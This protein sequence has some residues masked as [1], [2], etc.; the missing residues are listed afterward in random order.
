MDELA[1]SFLIHYSGGDD[2][3]ADVTF[4]QRYFLGFFCW[5]CSGLLSGSLGEGCLT[6][7][8][9]LLRLCTIFYPR[10]V[11]SAAIRVRS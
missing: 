7:G 3:L 11:V 2:L 10:V 9:S 8:F 5:L 1:L 4:E 6:F